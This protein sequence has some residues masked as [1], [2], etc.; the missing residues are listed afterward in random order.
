MTVPADEAA[1]T[2]QIPRV[3]VAETSAGMLVWIALGVLMG[4]ILPLWRGFDESESRVE[5]LVRRHGEPRA[6]RSFGRE[7]RRRIV[8][9]GRRRVHRPDLVRMRVADVPRR[10]GKRPQSF[11]SEAKRNHIVEERD[12][13]VP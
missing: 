8:R 13:H 9:Q 12:R 11:L 1:M 3:D 10:F 6:G 5:R 7:P 4:T 2:P